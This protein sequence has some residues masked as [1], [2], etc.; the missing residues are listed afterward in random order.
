[1]GNKTCFKCSK[2]SDCKK[3]DEFKDENGRV[4]IQILNTL[5]SDCCE[6]LNPKE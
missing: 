6:Y 5:A 2:M 1:M 3:L 4:N